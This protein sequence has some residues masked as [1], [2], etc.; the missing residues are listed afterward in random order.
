MADRIILGAVIFLGFVGLLFT[1]FFGSYASVMTTSSNTPFYNFTA[2]NV[3]FSNGG[4]SAVL[5]A[6]PVCK[7][8]E[9]WLI[10]VGIGASCIG[11]GVGWFISLMLTGSPIGYLA[12]VLTGIGAV[13]LLVIIRTVRGN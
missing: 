9:N 3:T 2:E 1:F 8:S 4:D 7:F 10:N 5:P 11:E 13:I 12:V 6:F